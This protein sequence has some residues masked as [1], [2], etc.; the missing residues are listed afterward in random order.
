MITG[1][2]LKHFKAMLA[3]K[4]VITARTDA[5][6]NTKWQ[7]RKLANVAGFAILLKNIPMGCQN[8]LFADHN[9]K[10]RFM[11][12]L[13]CNQKTGDNLSFFKSSVIQLHRE[14]RSEERTCIFLQLFMKEKGKVE[15]ATFQGVCLN[16]IQTAEEIL[17]INILS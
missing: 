13:T 4:R 16:E 6:V 17:G 5:M 1:D 10:E 11:N 14:E 12:C 9:L 8:E 7:F 3:G 2:D 15:S